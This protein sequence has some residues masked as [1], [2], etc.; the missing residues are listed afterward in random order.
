MTITGLWQVD[1]GNRL[2]A[3]RS[4]LRGLLDK[5]IVNALLVPL[6]GPGKSV[7]PALVKNPAL[8]AR[9]NPFAPVMAFNS[10]RLVSALT[11]ED[12]GETV[13]AVL[14]S[15]EIRALIELA[16][17]NQARLDKLVIVGVD[18]L[19][20]YT[21]PEFALAHAKSPD[22]TSMILTHAER[23]A[24]DDPAVRTA[25]KICEQPTTSNA[26]ISIGFIGTDNGNALSVAIRDDIAERLGIHEDTTFVANRDQA[27]SRLVGAR[28]TARDATLDDFRVQ[29]RSKG[30]MACYLADCLECTNC[31]NAC[32][33]CY[34]KECFFRTANAEHAP[35]E[36]MRLA[37]RQGAL[38]MPPDSVLFQLTRLNHMA[39][40]CVGCG[41]CEA[42]CPHHIPLTAMFRAVGMRVQKTFNY[43][44]GKDVNDK[45]P[46]MMF[47]QNE[48]LEIGEAK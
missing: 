20:T 7:M 19:G 34:C 18:C 21:V 26:D 39:T 41:M 24:C 36:L 46:F 16:K 4:L 27:L 8:L 48:L 15:C 13:G 38:A 14:R 12:S 28:M 32:P 1:D 35:R 37:E 25:C 45:P 42:A 2:E 10:A 43:V 30:G 44:P 5:R 22:L 9:A 29:I 40:S 33:I 6:E 17:F 31:M 47:Q 11:R 23:G 3:A